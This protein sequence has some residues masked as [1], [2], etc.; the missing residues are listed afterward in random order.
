MN[1]TTEVDTLDAIE[2]MCNDL[3]EEGGEEAV[4]FSQDLIFNYLQMVPPKTVISLIS[5]TSVPEDFQET[6]EA[7][8]VLDYLIYK[9]QGMIPLEPVIA[10][11]TAVSPYLMVKIIEDIR[12]KEQNT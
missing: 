5:R 4:G 12:M 8:Q 11:L 6:I 9:T 7:C 10:Y 2:L 1:F 3:I